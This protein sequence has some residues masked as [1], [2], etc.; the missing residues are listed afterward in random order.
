MRTNA[1][2]ETQWIDAVQRSVNAEKLMDAAE[3]LGLTVSEAI[4]AMGLYAAKNKEV[5]H[6]E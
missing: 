6:A 4:M 1:K 2:P 5:G 3:E